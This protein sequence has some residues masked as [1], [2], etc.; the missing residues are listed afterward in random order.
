MLG[1]PFATVRL[2]KVKFFRE[3][4]ALESHLS[5]DSGTREESGQPV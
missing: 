4:Q 1:A 3:E 2:L 5:G